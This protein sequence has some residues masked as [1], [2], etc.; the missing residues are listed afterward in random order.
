M[1]VEEE[2]AVLVRRPG[3]AHHCRPEKVHPVL[4]RPNLD[5]FCS[6]IYT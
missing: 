1:R 6:S 3:G 2:E 5:S 4:E